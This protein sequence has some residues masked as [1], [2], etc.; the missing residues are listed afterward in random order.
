MIEYQDYADGIKKKIDF[1]MPEKVKSITVTYDG[2]RLNIYINGSEVYG[3]MTAG[4]D[5]NVDIT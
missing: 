1:S 4:I 5:F 3:S 2:G